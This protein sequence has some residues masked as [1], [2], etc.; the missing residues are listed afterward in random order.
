MYH[1]SQTPH[2]L[3][4]PEQ[5]TTPGRPQGC[6]GT[7]EGLEARRESPL[8]LTSPPLWV[9]EETIRVVVFYWRSR[10]S[11]LFYIIRIRQALLKSLSRRVAVIIRGRINLEWEEQAHKGVMIR[12]GNIMYSNKVLC[13]WT[14]FLF[15][16]VGQAGWEK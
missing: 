10:A 4:S 13:S 7:G 1:P 16:S 14:Y 15:L 2:M 5:F 6:R 12:C 9:N 8:G 11:R 3:L